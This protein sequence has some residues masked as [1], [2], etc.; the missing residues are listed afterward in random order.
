[1]LSF[2]FILVAASLIALT[3]SK[4]I[5]HPLVYSE[6]DVFML[7]SLRINLH[8]TVVALRTDSLFSFT[9]I[10]VRNEIVT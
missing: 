5:V 9:I 6:L 8:E 7:P 4:G 1:M 2:H 3:Q 10:I